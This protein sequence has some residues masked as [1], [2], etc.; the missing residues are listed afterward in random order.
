MLL[1]QGLPA[2]LFADWEYQ[3]D[4]RSGEYRQ[5]AFEGMLQNRL[6]MQQ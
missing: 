4:L 2:C 3:Y 5:K 6:T 1:A